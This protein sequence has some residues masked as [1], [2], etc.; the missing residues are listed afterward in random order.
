M[1]LSTKE[2]DLGC[3]LIEM[4]GVVHE[5]VGGDGSHPRSKA[6]YSKLDEMASELKLAGYVPNTSEVL[7]D[8]GEEEKEDAL[9]RHSEKLALDFSLIIL[10]PGTT[11]RIVK[12]LRMCPHCH[13]AIKIISKLYGRKV[14]IRDR[15]RF[16]HFDDGFCSCKDFW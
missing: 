12:N 9:H 5:F 1:S 6:I 16:H 10:G 13:S 2:R 7:L 14:V 8:L 11:I 15:T 3:S 4:T